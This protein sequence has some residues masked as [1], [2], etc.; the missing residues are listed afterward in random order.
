MSQQS[1]SAS[2]QASSEIDPQA[3]RKVMSSWPTGVA[4]ITTRLEDDRKI[5]IL[6]N[7]LTS[8]SLPGKLLLWTV[9][10]ASSN[11]QHWANAKNWA[12]HFLADDQQDLIDRFARKGVAN[13]YEGLNCAISEAGTPILDD[14][15]ARLE[16]RTTETVVTLD[17]TIILGEVTAMTSSDRSPIIFAYSKFHKG[18]IRPE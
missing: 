3:F 9:D 4:I 5:G 15:V 7:S 13:K 1:D 17:H 14:V 12:V 18:P 8:I 10:H 16:C 2:S 11:H 6:C